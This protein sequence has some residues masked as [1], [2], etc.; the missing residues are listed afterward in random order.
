MA[1]R[2]LLTAQEVI[3]LT[4]TRTNLQANFIDPH[5][6]DAQEEH[7]EEV[8]TSPLYEELITELNA[9]TFSANNQILY[10]KYVKKYLAQ[11]ILHY[12]LVFIQYD[13]A[14]KGVR[15]NEDPEDTSRPTGTKEFTLLRE[16]I[17]SNAGT[18]YRKLI[19]ELTENQDKYPSYTPESDT[20]D[21]VTVNAGIIIH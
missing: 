2:K 17:R 13:I 11:M 7:L 9:A 14:D 6:E 1:N 18:K 4:G 20:P 12:A 8:L 3:D 5:I 19:K 15:V 10:D 21:K 16:S